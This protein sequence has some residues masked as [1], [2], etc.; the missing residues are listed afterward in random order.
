MQTF[1]KPKFFA[2]LYT[3]FFCGKK[4]IWPAFNDESIDPISGDLA[5]P[6][7]IGIKESYLY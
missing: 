2:K 4:S 6:M 1:G 5:A 7:R 3:P